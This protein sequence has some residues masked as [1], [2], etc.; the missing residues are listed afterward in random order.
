MPRYAFSVQQRQSRGARESVGIRALPSI[1]ANMRRQPL[2]S[3]VMPLLLSITHALA[4]SPAPAVGL[5]IRCC[6][7][8]KSAVSQSHSLGQVSPHARAHM[9]NMEVE[10]RAIEEVESS[11]FE[12]AE[13]RRAAAV[14]RLA[15]IRLLN[16]VALI[17][18]AIIGL[19]G[20]SIAYSLF[21]T[22]IR[23]IAALYYFD[24]G[25]DVYPGFARA[26]VAAD[27][28]A[29]LP[30]DLIHSYEELVPTNPVF[31]KACTS[32]VAY[33]L[34]DFISQI[35]Q[36]RDLKTIDLARSARSGTAGFIGHGPLCHYW[37]VFMV[38]IPRPSPQCPR[39]PPPASTCQHV[40]TLPCQ[41]ATTLPDHHSHSRA[42]C[43][44]PPAGDISRFRWRVVGDGLEGV[45]R[46]DRLVAL[47]QRNVLLLHWRPRVPQPS[48]RL[49]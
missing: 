7:R 20:L 48:G 27:L 2:I 35:F 11:A 39:L 41:H 28:L 43:P 6:S 5:R 21:G 30:F 37:M 18:G 12:D 45:C 25:P 44:S 31:Y 49:E 26:A 24:L 19:T 32:G 38:R 40:S 1:R 16:N 36:G 4:Y 10:T 22:D 29:R 47:P 42:A 46:P 17:N 14:M 23:A 34:G 9:I 8:R 15:R 33:T 3:V 13:S